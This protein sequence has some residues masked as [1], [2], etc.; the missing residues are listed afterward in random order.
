MPSD[1]RTRSRDNMNSEPPKE[2]EYSVDDLRKKRASIEDYREVARMRQLSAKAASEAARYKTKMRE[3]EAKVVK[4]THMA[5]SQRHK[6]KMYLEKKK[7][8]ESEIAN[9]AEQLRQSGL[10]AKQRAKMEIKRAKLTSLVAKLEL[11]SSQAEA[12][13]A[14]FTQKSALYQQRAAEF[15]TKHKEHELDARDYSNRADKLEKLSG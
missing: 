9:L 2:R 13:A 5:V 6:S 15:E 8:H 7:A 1:N 11:K 12:R 3:N 14:V 4:Y 10:E